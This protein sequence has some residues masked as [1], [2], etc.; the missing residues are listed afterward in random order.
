MD[1][2][3]LADAIT[4]VGC[5]VLGCHPFDKRLIFAGWAKLVYGLIAIIGIAL[6][7]IGFT[8]DVGWIALGGEATRRL[9]LQLYLARGIVLGLLF[10]L[11]LSRQLLGTKK[12]DQMLGK[13]PNQPPEATPGQ[14]PPAAPSPPSGAPQL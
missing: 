13:V 8:R 7:I 3:A 4:A 11:I 9:D 14:R 6:G 12:T 2:H 1:F 10:S 5:A